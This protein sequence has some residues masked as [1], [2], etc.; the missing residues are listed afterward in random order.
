MAVVAG[1]VRMRLKVQLTQSKRTYIALIFP[2]S[3]EEND[4][5]LNSLTA[6]FSKSKDLYFNKETLVYSP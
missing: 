2:W 1:D 6:L 3:V 4:L 5:Y